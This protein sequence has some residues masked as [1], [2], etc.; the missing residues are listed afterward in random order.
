MLELDDEIGLEPNLRNASNDT[1]EI[2]NRHFT[3]AIRM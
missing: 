1:L 3:T 2:D